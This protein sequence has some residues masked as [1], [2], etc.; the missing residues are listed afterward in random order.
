MEEINVGDKSILIEKTGDQT[1]VQTEVQR[2]R[3][4]RHKSDTLATISVKGIRKFFTKTPRQPKSNN[5]TVSIKS[6]NTVTKLK[7]PSKSKSSRSSSTLKSPNSKTTQGASVFKNIKGSEALKTQLER[8]VLK[9]PK[10]TNFLQA[11]KEVVAAIHPVFF[12]PDP[13]TNSMNFEDK[14]MTNG[15][16][17]LLSPGQLTGKQ[18]KRKRN[19]NSEE[20]EMDSPVIED[21]AEAPTAITLEVIYTMFQRL[22]RKVDK[23]SERTISEEAEKEVCENALQH[24]DNQIV[25]LQSA[26]VKMCSDITHN[27]HQTATLTA[28]ITRMADKIDDLEQKMERMELNDARKAA[29]I[30]NFLTGVKKEERLHDLYHFFLQELHVEIGIDDVYSIGQNQPPTLVIV[31]QTMEDKRILFDHKSALKSYQNPDKS[32]VYIKDYIPAATKEKRRREQDIFANNKALKPEEGKLNMKF[33]NG[34]LSIQGNTYRKKVTSPSPTELIDISPQRLTAILSKPLHKGDSVSQNGNTF[35]TFTAAV[36]SHQQIRE[37][38]IKMKLSYP[39]AKHIVCAYMIP[40]AEPH[41]DMDYCDD[42][43]HGA[44]QQVLKLMK[45]SK[46]EARVLFVVRA[47]NGTKLGTDR[48]ECYVQSAKS[49]ML[50]HPFSSILKIHQKLAVKESSQ[51]H[52]QSSGNR[53]GTT[54]RYSRNP[55]TQQQPAPQRHQYKRSSLTE[56]KSYAQAANPPTWPTVNYKF[57]DPQ[58]CDSLRNDIDVD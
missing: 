56:P 6:V 25:P 15:D 39:T 27:R 37:F 58:Q 40:G 26:Q 12:P 29:T 30:S 46:L 44:G 2:N 5:R 54:N 57:S 42:G 48:H 8:E 50:K 33:V 51:K 55:S 18:S 53:R 10:D 13:V 45:E 47:S 7:G 19:Q 4:S 32:K 16:N 9:S 21:Q 35:T 20:V 28:V 23:L 52:M 24:V 3:R 36:K 43:D 31:F 22:E 1:E 17:I 49:A 41:Y 11:S 14:N 38:Y 34:N